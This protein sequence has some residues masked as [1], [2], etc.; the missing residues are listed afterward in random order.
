MDTDNNDKR[1][2]VR[3]TKTD[4]RIR[5]TKKDFRT[6]LSWQPRWEPEI[7]G[8]AIRYILKTKPK[9]DPIFTV[10]DL[11]QDAYVQF[12]V[13]ADGYPRV[14]EGAHFMALY[15]STLRNYLCDMIRNNIRRIGVIDDTITELDD[16][17]ELVSTLNNPHLG[18]LKVLISEAPIE[19]RALLVALNTDEGIDELRKPLRREAGRMMPRESL[20]RRLCRIANVNPTVNLVAKLKELL[21]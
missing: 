8:W 1:F 12:L 19:V 4:L 20:N 18:Y 3:L 17:F 6:K 11:I 7:K 5:L 16:D 10:Q 14:I 21:S 2:R 13:C 9:L 15:Q